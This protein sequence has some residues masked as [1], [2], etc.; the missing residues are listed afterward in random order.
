MRFR[1]A[2]SAGQDNYASAPDIISPTQDAFC[3]LCHPYTGP[4]PVAAVKA[5]ELLS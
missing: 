4:Y 2:S 5:R 1:P 3:D